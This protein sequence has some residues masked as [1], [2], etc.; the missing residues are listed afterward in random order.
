MKYRVHLYAIVRVEHELEATSPG[1]AVSKLVATHLNL[2]QRFDRAG[3][4][5]ADD[6]DKWVLVDPLT[7]HADS[8]GRLEPDIENSEWLQVTGPVH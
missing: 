6:F 2:Y 1:D 5:Y 3:Q 7:E 8:T 4:E